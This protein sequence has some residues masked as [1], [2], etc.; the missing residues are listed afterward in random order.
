MYKITIFIM[1]SESPI[2]NV[3]R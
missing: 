3:I 2:R 1:L